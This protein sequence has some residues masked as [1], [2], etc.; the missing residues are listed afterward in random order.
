V[1]KVRDLK[2]LEH[3]ERTNALRRY[4]IWVWYHIES[5]NGEKGEAYADA[6]PLA[7]LTLQLLSE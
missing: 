1:S 3:A 5:S 4:R 7:A 2:H 6:L